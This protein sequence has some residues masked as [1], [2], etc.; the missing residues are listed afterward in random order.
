MIDDSSLIK[1][2]QG[3]IFFIDNGQKRLIKSQRIF[4]ELDFDKKD[5]KI[6]NDQM[7]N[8]IP[9]GRDINFIYDAIVYNQNDIISDGSLIMGT[10]KKVYLMEKGKKRHILSPKVF[11]QLQ[12]SKKEIMTIDD[13]ILEQIPVGPQIVN[14]EATDEQIIVMIY[15]GSFCNANRFY[16]FDLADAFHQL[17]YELKTV[18]LTKPNA[19][20]KLNS[21]LK[22]N[23]IFFILGLNGNGI[24]LLHQLI[25][26]N[27]LKVPYLALLVDHPMYHSDRPFKFDQHQNIPYVF[28]QENVNHHGHKLIFY[29]LKS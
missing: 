10:S 12:R 8:K 5:I 9:S 20:G 26:K 15:S 19:A 23:N 7:I 28:L 17:G 11:N 1:D 22:Q 14:K 4:D 27:K 24:E 16:A 2:S 29:L 13:F 25:Y 21:I 3:R 18:D 6:V